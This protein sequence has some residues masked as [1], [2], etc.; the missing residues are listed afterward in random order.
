[1]TRR[2]CRADVK[3]TV[4]HRGPDF[5]LCMFRP[6]RI[7]QSSHLSGVKT[8]VEPSYSLTANPLLNIAIGSNHLRNPHPNPLPEREGS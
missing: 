3:R 1:M 5:H 2:E 8:S 4:T 7:G 6:I